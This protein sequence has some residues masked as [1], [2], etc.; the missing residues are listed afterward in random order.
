MSL[1]VADMLLLRRVLSSHG[2]ATGQYWIVLW[3]ARNFTSK[4]LQCQTFSF[5]DEKSGE[6]SQQHEESKD[7]ENVIQPWVCVGSC[8]TTSTQRHNGSLSDD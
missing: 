7:L 4:L 3:G 1:P 5:W 8:S 2:S 6:A